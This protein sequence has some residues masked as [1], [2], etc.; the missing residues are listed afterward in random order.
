[1]PSG[2]SYFGGVTDWGFKILIL[3]VVLALLPQSPFSLYAELVNDIPYLNYL[4]WFIPMS[5]IV[6]VVEAWLVVVSVY[7]GYMVAL[8]YANALK[9]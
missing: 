1:M 2:A 9:G 3:S 8:R 7:Y 5:E 4:N 6:L